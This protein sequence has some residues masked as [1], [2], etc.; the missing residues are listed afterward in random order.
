MM[1]TRKGVQCKGG[2]WVPGLPLCIDK[3]KVEGND[4]DDDDD[5]DD[6]LY[7]IGAVCLTRKS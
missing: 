6:D 4:D 7:I 1:I 5:D 2:Q 3:R